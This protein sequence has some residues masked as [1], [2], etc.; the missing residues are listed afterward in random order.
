[1]MLT[2]L[3]HSHIRVMSLFLTNKSP[4]LGYGENDYD[5]RYLYID[6]DTCYYI[7]GLVRDCMADYLFRKDRM[8]VFIDINWIKSFKNNLSVKGF[9]VEKAC[10][11]SICRNGITANQI[12]FK[13]DGYQ[14]FSSTGEIN[15]SWQEEFYTFY[16]PRKWN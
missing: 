1:M 16:L 2:S 10:L 8:E 9:I 12:T 5:H 7:C 15:F 13:V 3:F 6:N 14:F 4:L 11:A